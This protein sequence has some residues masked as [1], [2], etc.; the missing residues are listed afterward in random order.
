VSKYATIAIDSAG[1]LA[2]M[3]FSKSMGKKAADLE[4]IR[5]VNNYPGATER[6]NMFVRRCKDYRDRAGI[7]IVFT[8]HEDLQ[9]VYARG[10]QITP[11]G[12][13][14]QE[15]IA[16]RGWP[17]LP[18]RTAPDEFCRAVDNVFHMRYLNSAP[19]WVTKRESLGGGGDYWDVKDRFNAS[20]LNGG[21]CPPSFTEVEKL[22]KANPLCNWDPPYIWLLYG[23]FGIGKTR[24]LITFPRPIK[25]WD[26]D[27]GTKSIGREIKDSN[28]EI[29][30]QTYNPEDTESYGSF[31]AQMEAD[32]GGK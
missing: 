30:V 24:C 17:D 19:V 10:G 32:C 29:T 26:L 3:A 21:F 4:K 22:A 16:V 11:K 1:E 25:I 8:A 31:L 9:R 27:S 5:E 2:R 18:G 28:G 14:Q 12:K 6:L 20:I 15:P 7:N 13:E 23:P